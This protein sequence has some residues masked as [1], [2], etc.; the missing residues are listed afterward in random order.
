MEERR[1][2]DPR[3][4]YVGVSLCSDW[5]AEVASEALGG[6]ALEWVAGRWCTGHSSSELEQLNPSLLDLDL[7]SWSSRDV[8][9]DGPDEAAMDSWVESSRAGTVLAIWAPRQLPGC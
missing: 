1:E 8:S 4:V 7:V 5:H 6:L 2:N 3:A 9:I